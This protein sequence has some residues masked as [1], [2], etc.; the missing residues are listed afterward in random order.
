MN[1]HLG[2]ITAAAVASGV[3][4][5]T[6]AITALVRRRNELN[7]KKAIERDRAAVA[8][9]QNEIAG[10]DAQIRGIEGQIQT[11]RGTESHFTSLF[12]SDG[13]GPAIAAIA[14]AGLIAAIALGG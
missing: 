4:S 2:S 11:I 14:G 10:I 13:K 1:V 5:A 8:R 7:A 12:K 6:S 9:I 3:S